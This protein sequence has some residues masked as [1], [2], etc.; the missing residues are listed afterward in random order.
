MMKSF[1]GLSVLLPLLASASPILN[2]PTIHN[3]AA[4]ILS[5]VYSQEIPDSYMIVFK[6]HVKRGNAAAHHSWVHDLHLSSETTKT[7][8]RKRSQIPLIGPAFEGLKHTYDIGGLL[9]GYSGHFDEDVIEQIRR[10]PDVGS[11][12][13][14]LVDCH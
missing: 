3:E 8:L 13:A 10:H 9:L 12:I 6:E 1:V 5:S 7:E 2:A 14:L 4:P 11:H